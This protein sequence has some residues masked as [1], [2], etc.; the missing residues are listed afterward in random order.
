VTGSD[1]GD[2]VPA[3][4]SS[5]LTGPVGTVIPSGARATGVI[6]SLTGPLGEEQIVFDIRWISV[7][8]TSYRVSTRVTDFELDR[9]AGA[10]RCMPAGAD[11]SA[12]LT[13]PLK[14]RL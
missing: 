2:R 1:V 9:R 6:T 5:R 7:G 11:I 12:A 14:I 13:E 3:R 4:T 10:E 8:G